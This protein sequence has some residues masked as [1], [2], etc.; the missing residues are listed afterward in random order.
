MSKPFEFYPH[1]FTPAAIHISLDLE[2]VSLSSDAA[3]IQI[4]A[5]AI[6][7][8]HLKTFTQHISL[9]SN[10]AAKRDVSISTMEWWN[11]QDPEL[12]KRV[13][14][15]TTQLETALDMFIDWCMYLSGDNLDN[16]ILWSKP[17]CFDIPVLRNAIE[18]FREYPFGPRNV[19]DV[20]T[21]LRTVPVE[22]QERRHNNIGYNYPNLQPHDALSDAIYQREMIC[23]SL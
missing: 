20:Y 1:Y 4:G 21:L 13:F 17:Q 11:K 8:K 10:E 9:A 12:R 7:T 22:E 16:I 2:T 5:A 14:G 6:T 23:Q 15:G 3:I 18:C 19:G